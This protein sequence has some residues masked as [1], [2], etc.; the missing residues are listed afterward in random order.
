M[1][2]FFRRKKEYTLDD[3]PN[4]PINPAKLRQSTKIL[5]VDDEPF[6]NED[7][8][9]A[10]GFN[11]TVKGCWQ[12]I[13][14]A[15]PYQ[16]I[17][18]DNRGVATSF[19]SSA[20]GAFVLNQIHER[21]PQKGCIIYSDSAIDFSHTPML[22]GIKQMKKQDETSEWVEILSETIVEIHDPRFIWRKVENYLSDQNVSRK[23]LRKMEDC[24]VRNLIKDN[25]ESFDWAHQELD[26]SKETIEM[27]SNFFKLAAT[28]MAMMAS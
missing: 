11:I 15:E 16:I 13:K 23:M 19:R 28:A 2:T 20:E 18:S 27:I 10:L 7:S 26:L 25:G 6:D 21:Y 1:T 9:K 4:H 22:S 8:L 17:V 3:L 5:I 24:Y 12:D 14:D